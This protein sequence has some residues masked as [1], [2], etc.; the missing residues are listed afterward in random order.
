MKLKICKYAGIDDEINN[1]MLKVK[2]MSLSL[3]ILQEGHLQLMDI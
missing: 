2:N 3:V 1:K